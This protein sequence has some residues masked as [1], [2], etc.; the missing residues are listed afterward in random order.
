MYLTR[1][2]VKNYKCLGEIDI[3][4]TPIHVLIGENDSGKSSLLEAMEIFTSSASQDLNTLL[5]RTDNKSELVC[6]HSQKKEI[7]F[8]GDLALIEDK[9]N[10][11][12]P[13]K[14]AIE[15][16]PNIFFICR[17]E[18]N[19]V[20][21]KQKTGLTKTM[22]MRELD[23]IDIPQNNTFHDIELLIGKIR[24]ILKPAQSYSFIA[25][26]LAKPA[27][28]NLENRFK[29]ERNGFGLAKLL[30]DLLEYDASQYLKL[31]DD[32]RK[33]FP[34]FKNIKQDKINVS[35]NGIGKR[36]IFE[37][38]SGNLIN[39]NMAS[40][41]ALLIL[42]YLTLTYVPAPPPILL[43][44]EPENGIYPK[45]LAEVIT[46][47]KKLAS[48]TNGVKFPQ[49]ILTTHSPLVLSY[50][51]P[52]EVTFLSRPP[53]EPDGPVRAR[54]LRD[55]PNI[56]ERM[57]GEFYLGELWYNLSEEDLFGAP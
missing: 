21:F 28:L 30:D 15:Y 14:F 55:A 51:E 34:Q 37:T 6:Y 18:I 41:G 35:G 44:E 25:S 43:I 32:F 36:I 13:Y 17:E 10:Q 1:F 50:F 53:N 57:G 38:K 7:E 11:R 52:E 5:P 48:G 46:L 40:D 26:E 54:P 42:G 23:N 12:V 49:I 8:S 56:K 45:K 19:G 4:L 27:P 33:L 22:F 9:I 16:H 29:I 47:L 31:C 24:G 2:G 3:P 39:A 20:S